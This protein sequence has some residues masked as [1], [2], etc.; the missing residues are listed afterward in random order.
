MKIIILGDS[1]CVINN[2]FY[3]ENPNAHSPFEKRT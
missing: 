1:F 3:H 2:D